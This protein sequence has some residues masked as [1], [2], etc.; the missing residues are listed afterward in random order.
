MSTSTLFKLLILIVVFSSA[1]FSC[2]TGA[3]QVPG[4]FQFNGVSTECTAAAQ[5]SAYGIETTIS[6][7]PSCSSE[8]SGVTCE[9]E[10]CVY[11][12][13]LSKC[14]TLVGD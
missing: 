4:S 10:A 14:E 3:Q 13:G 6:L 9:V 7:E 5:F 8:G 12:L 2:V 1:S 11:A